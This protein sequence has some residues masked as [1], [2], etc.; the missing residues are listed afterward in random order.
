M[1]NWNINTSELK[2]NPERYAIWKLEQ[3]VNFGLNGTKLKI[4][5]LKKYWPKL[6]IDPQRK[7]L[8]EMWLWQKQS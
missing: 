4:S 8:L 5:E 6:H 2:K 1:Y 3:S 7:K